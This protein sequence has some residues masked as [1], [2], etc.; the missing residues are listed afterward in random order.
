MK[1]PTK[2]QADALRHLAAEGGRDSRA[3]TWALSTITGLAKRKFVTWDG[4]SVEITTAG[5]AW[6]AKVRRLQRRLPISTAPPR[7]AKR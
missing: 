6:L 4:P 7:K 1:A 5:H 3:D 2:A